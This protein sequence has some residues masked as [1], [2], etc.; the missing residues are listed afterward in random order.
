MTNPRARKRVLILGGGF[1]GLY[2]ALG[3]EKMLAPDNDIEVTL[4]NRQNFSL[5]TPMLHEVAASDLDMTHIVNPVRKLLRRV[6][7]FHGDVEHIDLTLKQVTV[8][9]GPERHGHV[10]GYDHLVLA[11]GSTTN[12]FGLPQLEQRALTMKSLSDAA[13]LRSRLIVMLEE[14]DFECAAS[15][16]PKLLSIVVVGGGFAGAETVAAVN[17]FLRESI[18]LY[19][20]LATDMLRVVLVHPGDVI[21]PELGPKLGAYAQKKLAE[22]K[23][24]IRVN[25]RVIRVDD[26]AVELS[27]GSRIPT[28]TVIWTAGTSPNPLIA[29][30]PCT[31]E[32]GRIVTDEYLEVR[33]WPGVWALG[34]CASITDPKTGR[35][36]PP[37]AQHALRQGTAVANN[38][39]AAIRGG[40]KRPF[41]FSTLGLMAAIGRRTGVANI[42]GIN[43]SGFAAW[44]LWRSIYLS[45]LPR[46]E[47]KVRVALD[48]TLDLL[49]GK[50]LVCIADSRP[51]IVSHIE[52][53]VTALVVPKQ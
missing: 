28:S 38:V 52:E 15:S 16:R 53:D 47:K 5:F 43:F 27:D 18:R 36:Y 2:T 22:R 9:H 29:T 35:P 25:A 4:V 11:L 39:I 17:D 50:D 8:V 19:P 30:L 33:D 10:L 14:A 21:L 49:F 34:D 3:L 42:L 13:N 40:S 31:M 44:F 32:R 48:W 1:G 7:F 41:S 12:F 6:R 46:F 45:K 26:D 23:V 20:H 24:E 37:T 51:P